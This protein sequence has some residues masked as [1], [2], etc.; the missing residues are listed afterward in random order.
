ML[1]YDK[2]VSVNCECHLFGSWT[3]EKPCKILLTYDWISRIVNA[4]ELMQF[5]EVC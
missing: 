3:S 2:N 1:S 4:F 5:V